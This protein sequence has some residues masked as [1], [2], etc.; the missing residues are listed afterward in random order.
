MVYQAQQKS[1]PE[2]RLESI[3]T[4]NVIPSV[5]MWQVMWIN[6]NTVDFD[7][8]PDHVRILSTATFYQTDT[9]SLTK[10]QKAIVTGQVI[11]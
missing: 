5:M 8:I 11:F 9:E 2:Q 4:P 7:A 6:S 1:D 10:S 3:W